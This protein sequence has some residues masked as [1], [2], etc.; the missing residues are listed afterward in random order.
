MRDAH[1]F[2]INIYAS[3]YLKSRYK[4]NRQFDLKALQ[5]G[6]DEALSCFLTPPASSSSR[7]LP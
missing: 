7:H 2:Y 1:N 6:K 3:L 5:T 4:K